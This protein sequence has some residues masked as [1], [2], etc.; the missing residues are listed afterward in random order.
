MPSKDYR[1][2]LSETAYVA[3]EFV[4]VRGWVV[5]FVVRLMLVEDGQESNVAR[6]DT[7]HGDAPDAL[8]RRR[9]S[10]SKTM[11]Y[12]DAPAE[13]VLHR[14]VD[15]SKGIMKVISH[16]FATCRRRHLPRSLKSPVA[17]ADDRT[18]VINRLRPKG[19]GLST[20]KPSA[21]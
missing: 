6:W 21:A 10:L 14:A 2:W 18:P 13:I 19:P 5:S 12:V 9:G 17:K 1:I 8:G 20:P 7:A 16:D 11:W 3:V 4:M 15:D